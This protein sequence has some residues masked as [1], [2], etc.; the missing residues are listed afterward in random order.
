MRRCLGCMEEYEEQYNVCPHCGYAEGAMADN[1]LHINPGNIVKGMNSNYTIGKVLGSGSFGVTYVAWDNVLER[2]VAIKEYMPSEYSTRSSG[3]TM[4]EVTEEKRELFSKGMGK[5]LEEARKLAKFEE[6]GIVRIFDHFYQNDTAYIVMEY[7]D[8]ITLTEYLEQNGKM[9]PKMAVDMLM[10]VMNSLEKVHSLGIVHRDIA[11]D[12]IMITKDGSIKLIDFG[13]ARFTSSSSSKSL[14]VLVKPGYSPEEQYRRR[15]DQGPHT[16]VYSLA[17]TLYKMITGETP[18]DALERRAELESR[19]KN[20]LQPIRKYN[21]KISKNIENAIYNAMNIKIEDRT[22]TIRQFIEELT[23]EKPV[24]LRDQTIPL[25][26]RLRWRPWQIV[27][28]SISSVAVIILIALLSTGVIH[29]DSLFEEKFVLP[30]GMTRVPALIN[31]DY[32]TANELLNEASLVCVV[33]PK[34]YYNAIPKDKVYKQSLNSGMITDINN[35][36][37]IWV[38]DGP[39]MLDMPSVVG[40][41]EETAIKELEANSVEYDISYEYSMNAKGTV[42]EQSHE[43]GTKI[44]IGKKVQIIVSKGPDP[45]ATIEEKMVTVPDL[46]NMDYQK[47]IETYGQEMQIVVEKRDWSDSYGDFEKDKIMVQDIKAGTTIKNTETAI[48][49]IVSD[50]KEMYEVP[51]V[52]MRTEESA[53]AMLEAKH[54]Q[55][56][57]EYK[58]HETFEKGMVISQSIDGGEFV[59]RDTSITIVVSTGKGA[60]AMADVVGMEE[61]KAK[62]QLVGVGLNVQVS[63]EHS[64]S[65]SSGKVISQSI[66]AGT[67]VVAGDTVSIVISSGEELYE[68]PNVVGETLESAKNKL[69]KYFNVKTVEEYTE[70]K[71]GSVYSQSLEA[72]TKYKKNTEILLVVSKGKQPYTV[73]FEGEGGTVSS[74]SMTVYYNDVYGNLPTC[75]K[76]GYTFAGWYTSSAG[77]DKITETSKYTLQGNSTLYAHWTPNTYVITF[78]ANGGTVGTGSASYKYGGTYSNMPTPTREQ[79]TFV[80][81]YTE[82]SGGTEVTS[83][84]KVTITSDQTLYAHWTANQWS[85]WKETK[86]SDASKYTIKEKTQYRYRDK[87]FTTCTTS[88]TMSG[89]TY[90]STESYWSDYGAWSDWSTNPVT[91]SDS[92][93]VD[94]QYVQP[95]YATKYQYFHYCNGGGNWG[96]WASTQVS[97]TPYYHTIT[98]DA[99]LTDGPYPNQY[100]TGGEYWKGSTG[101][102]NGCTRWY[103]GTNWQGHNSTVQV[104]T[105]GGY[106]LYR[107]RDRTLQYKYNFWRW[108]S[109]SSWSDSSVTSTTS[110]DVE[111]RKLYNYILK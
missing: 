1:P 16:D 106:T 49:V 85:G 111:T 90:S 14:T 50:G 56:N 31:K 108:G 5:F 66:K 104:Q 12:N 105:G 109:W 8:G 43:G 15:G 35:I 13:A 54:L 29:F 82:S 2:K 101:C 37:E 97:N 24:K 64:D 38:S 36:V 42:M 51:D 67:N 17:A 69:G 28:A 61:S 76:T 52:V 107:Y 91:A 20:I 74:K 9:D 89:W 75:T 86:P 99:Q 71:K 94:P 46:I 84:T 62:N 60:F 39:Q 55:I 92:R 18:K 59:K 30:E 45:N 70:I 95:T 73:T 6:D 57:V 34:E 21:R 100:G 4:V 103:V 98:F 10:P 40:M 102:T 58:T 11:P 65:V 19:K 27:I 87:E 83:S 23:S 26:D 7:L 68:V 63:Y 41:M 32:E 110:R 79:Y 96:T 81:W 3:H 47:A 48:K 88:S 78:N 22:P 44:V 33:K 77:G 72:G 93:Q 53:K 80:G 25:I